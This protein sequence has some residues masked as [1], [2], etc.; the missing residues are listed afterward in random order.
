MAKIESLSDSIK[1]ARENIQTNLKVS[2]KIKNESV[3]GKV[4]RRTLGLTLAFDWI[5][6]RIWPV[7]RVVSWPV[8]TLV[9][10][11]LK[12]WDWAVYNKQGKLNIPRAGGFLLASAAFAWF[13]LIPTL[14][15]MIDCGLY[16]TTAKHNDSVYLFNAQ[17]IDPIENIHSVQGCYKLPCTDQD[18]IYFRI[19]ATPFNEAWNIVHHG[20]FF[21]SDYVAAA[22]PITISRC[23]ITSYGIRLRLFMRFLNMYPDMLESTCTPMTTNIPQQ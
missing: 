21:F 23:T 20:E 12:F 6:A 16:F 22:I 14:I 11:W 8:R 17:E 13:M 2:E 4:A 9:R 7:Y 15:F 19:R 10:Y 5:T 1:K 3:Y 18:S